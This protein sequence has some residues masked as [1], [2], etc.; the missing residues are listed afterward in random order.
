MFKSIATIAL[1]QALLS[2]FAFAAEKTVKIA[3]GSWP[4]FIGKELEGY[5]S[6]AQT[7]KQ[8][9]A[10]EG[11]QVTF[12]FYPWARAYEKAKNGEYHATAVWMFDEQR[13]EHFYFSEPVSQEEF[14][15]F[16]HKD[17]DF[18]W[19][20]LT[21]IQNFELG[22]G[23]GYSYGSELDALIESKTVRINRVKTPSQNLLLLYHKRI[24]LY[25]EEQ[26]IGLYNLE[27]QSLDVQSQI[28]YHPTPFLSN[29][30][31]VM[32][33]KQ[34]NTSKELLTIFNQGLIKI[35]QQ[36]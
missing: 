36:Q 12:T 5:G 29:F 13:T 35:R 10:I 25:P 28:T 18:D 3:V 23:L 11:Y 33:S 1:A 30:G 4:P 32:F 17:L 8:A 9:F 2:P 16:H 19:L 34:N 22:G 7:I 31:Y 24:D 15:F 14:V 6:V 26:H 21:D 27:Q 20:T